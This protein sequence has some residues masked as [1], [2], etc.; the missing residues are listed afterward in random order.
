MAHKNRG[1][2]WSNHQTWKSMDI[3][4]KTF[5]AAPLCFPEPFG[6]VSQVR[7]AMARLFSSE[8]SRRAGG[9]AD[10]WRSLL[11]PEMYPF[12]AFS[13]SPSW[14]DF[15]GNYHLPLASPR[16]S[17]DNKRFHVQ[18]PCSQAT[19]FCRKWVQRD[20]QRNNCQATRRC[21]GQSTFEA[22]LVN[23]CTLAM[24]AAG[25]PC[26]SN[27]LSLVVSLFEW[28][29]HPFSKRIKPLCRLSKQ[30]HLPSCGLRFTSI[31]IQKCKI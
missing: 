15:H 1:F 4:T 26:N 16:L 5:R 3:K 31:Y 24:L 29:P 19:S 20:R 14:K 17:L 11:Q 27:V 10:D 25:H 9:S 8:M 21:S 7:L 18:S 28:L 12:V 2:N 6:S 23:N 13:F 30:G 22:D